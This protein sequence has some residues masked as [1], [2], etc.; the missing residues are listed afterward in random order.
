METKAG[1]EARDWAELQEPT[2]KPLWE[3][4]LDA[5][6]TGKGTALLDAGCGAGGAGL[7]AYERSALITGIDPAKNSIAQAR[8]RLPSADF[9]VGSMAALPFADATFDAVIAANA[10]QFVED[11]DLGLA[12]LA[13]VCKPSGFVSVA[14]FGRPEQVDEDAVFNAITDLMP[15]RHAFTEYRFSKPGLLAEMLA[16]AV[17]SSVTTQEI[18]TPFEYPDADTGWCAQRSAGSIQEAIG[19]VGEDRVKG[20]VIGAFARFTRAGGTVHLDNI[21]SYATGKR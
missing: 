11:A 5:T 3:A 21:M 15:T 14:I 2:S 13:R 18:N 19:S 12:E 20:A 16:K 6:G 4:M 17:L 9:R 7:I 10:I 1:S 8:S